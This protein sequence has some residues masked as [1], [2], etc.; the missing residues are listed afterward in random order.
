MYDQ[1]KIK[2]KV[3]WAETVSI[4]TKFLHHTIITKIKK[5][6]IDDQR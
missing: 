6:V 5:N 1:N 4:F 2:A 3:L